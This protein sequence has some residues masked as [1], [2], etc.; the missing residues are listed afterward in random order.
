MTQDP[1]ED[2]A[3]ETSQK[4]EPSSGWLPPEHPGP[5]PRPYGLPSGMP[6]A[7]PA[8]EKYGDPPPWGYG[9][10]GPGPYGGPPPVPPYPPP[11]P[12]QPYIAYGPPMVT[13]PTLAEPWQ[14]FIA[15]IIDA[16]VLFVV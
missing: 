14:R 3:A 8:S 4:A 16:L 2:R 13:D 12:R 5:Q 6:H 11:P 10:P 1:F 15:R 7:A 9:N